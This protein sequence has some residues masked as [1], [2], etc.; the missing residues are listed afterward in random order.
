MSTR[1]SMKLSAVGIALLLNFAMIGSV[2]YFFHAHI[3]RTPN[4]AGQHCGIRLVAL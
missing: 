3:D 4:G 1:I 2:A